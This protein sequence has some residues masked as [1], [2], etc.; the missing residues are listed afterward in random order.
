MFRVYVNEQKKNSRFCMDVLKEERETICSLFSLSLSTRKTTTSR[1]DH[2]YYYYYYYYVVRLSVAV[3]ETRLWRTFG[4]N[5]VVVGV[6]I[7][8]FVRRASQWRT[9]RGRGG[10]GRLFCSRWREGRGGIDGGD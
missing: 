8:L 9:P 5:A 10:R 6:Q 1:D 2:Y 4:V 7:I 3:H